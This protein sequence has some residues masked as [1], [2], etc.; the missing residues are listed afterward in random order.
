MK[1]S[2]FILVAIAAIIGL[3]S[4]SKDKADTAQNT[5]IEGRWVGTHVNNASGNTFYYSFNVK[6]GGVIEEINQSGQKIGEGTWKLENDILTAAYTWPSGSKY[7]V[8]AFYKSTAKL[9]GDWGY[10]SSATN[11][12]T[13]QMNKQGN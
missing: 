7:S 5:I 3:A 1:I 11:G 9:L 8:I 12:G 4:C 10:G 2:K 13:W 6:P